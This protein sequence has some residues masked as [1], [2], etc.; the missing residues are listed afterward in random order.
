MKK[1]NLLLIASALFTLGLTNQ[2]IIEETKDYQ[3]NEPLNVYRNMQIGKDDKFS[4]SKMYV[5]HGQIDGVDCLR[6]A[7]AIKGN[8]DKISY[9]RKSFDET[10]DKEKE[11]VSIYESI[12]ANGEATYFDGTDTTTDSTF[13]K[14]YYWACYTIKFVTD[15]YKDKDITMSLKVNDVVQSTLTA[16]LTKII[17]EEKE[18]EKLGEITRIEYNGDPIKVVI[19]DTFGEI[20]QKVKVTYQNSN[21]EINILDRG[22]ESK[23]ITF[24]KPTSNSMIGMK[25]VIK[26]VSNKNK[27]IFTEIPAIIEKVLQGED[28]TIVGGNVNTETEWII[29]E[30]NSISQK[31]NITFAGGFGGSVKDN[32][33]AYL[34]FDI[35]SYSDCVVDL[36][37]RCGN[38][39]LKKDTSTSPESFW[40]EELQ[41]NK[42]LDMYVNDEKREIPNDVTLASVCKNNHYSSFEPLYNIYSLFTFTDVNVKAGYNKIKLQFKDSELRN[43]WDESP[44]TLNIDYISIISKESEIIDG[45]LSEIKI[46]HVDE[47][48]LNA[49]L[50]GKYGNKYAY[51]DPNEY[52][53]TVNRNGN[54]EYEFNASLNDK[55]LS[56][57]Q[58]YVFNKKIDAKKFTL[59]GN[60]R[61]FVNSANEYINDNGTYK[62][63]ENQINV[64]YGMDNS[65]TSNVE[66]SIT[67]DV[68]VA[69]DGKYLLSSRLSNTYYFTENDKHLAKELHLNQV[70]KLKVNGKYVD[71]DDAVLQS[72]DPTDNGDYIYM[73]FFEKALA[74]I[75]LKKGKNTISLEVNNSSS[76]RNIYKEIPVPRIN[77]VTIK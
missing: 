36:N 19:G 71:L 9:I 41:I 6:F 61:V 39:Y 51:L 34:E 16:N 58:T 44:S 46:D 30:D 17:E 12:L 43:S 64:V 49:V 32:K 74:T 28:A 26:V 1:V 3:A 73:Q 24:I 69:I 2:N 52:T 27:N 10:A 50:I 33:P 40:M 54:Y 76:L 56:C 35:N 55:P 13:A 48:T 42:I 66:T 70:L 59:K 31:G 63:S 53:L 25:Y 15:T 29:N 57:K 4:A 7:T 60:D 23:D 45:E 14:D 22:I 21:G 47:N 75:E 18:T 68:N 67:F 11:V 65:A 8:I 37:L 72:V 62:P 77:C 38:S 5:Q 20:T